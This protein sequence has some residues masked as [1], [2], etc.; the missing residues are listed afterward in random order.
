MARKINIDLSVNTGST[1]K[2]IANIDSN[3]E[4]LNKTVTDIGK[5]KGL[6]DFGD[7]LSNVEKDFDNL[8]TTV[9]DTGT[10]IEKTFNDGKE[11]TEKFS[12][13]SIRT[14]GSLRKELAN[15]VDQLD[16]V[17]VG[18][19]EFE[20]LTAAINDTEEAIS[21]TEGAFGEA[22]DRLR[23]LSGSGVERARASFGLLR[24]GITNL[25]LGK[26]QVGLKGLT[27]NF[28]VLGTAIAATGIG[29]LVGLISNLITNFDKLKESGGAIGAL[30]TGIGDGISFITD[31]LT[32]LTD[33][34]GLTDTETTKARKANEKYTQSFQ[35]LN[36]EL[37]IAAIKQRELSGDITETEGKTLLLEANF[38]SQRIKARTDFL[39]AIS[40]LD[41]EKDSVEIEN[42]KKLYATRL[43]V[44]R[45]N[46]NN[47]KLAIQNS[48]KAKTKTISDAEAKR[49]KQSIDEN[50]KRRE[51]ELKN[52]QKFFEELGKLRL[53]ELTGEDLILSQQE[54]KKQ[55]II[56]AFN[57]LTK[58]EQLKQETSF[59]EQLRLIN[60]ETIKLQ[61]EFRKKQ[62]E[63]SLDALLALA[64]EEADK[65]ASGNEQLE[66]AQKSYTE[67]L[68]AEEEKRKEALINRINT[69]FEITKQGF[70]AIASLNDL[71]STLENNRNI[72]NEKEL[73]KIQKRQFRRNQ[74]L[75]AT[76]T[77]INT[78][79]SIIK[80]GA[81]LGY[82]AAIPFQIGAGIAGAAQIASILAKRFDGNTPNTN[83]TT[84]SGLD[85]ATPVSP[86]LPLLEQLGALP[87][88][89][90]SKVF[91]TETDITNVLN[92]VQVIET[93]STFG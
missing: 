21:K 51:Q 15:L 79:E 82:P 55:G 64:N 19:P 54:E 31:N 11:A 89:Q 70:E 67:F 72:T 29:L 2:D 6:D 90:T 16:T 28:R 26:L 40:N 84:P 74:V 12:T 13:A 63:D 46:E 34:I 8:I 17:E 66:K 7:S 73:L 5:N 76:Q 44:I 60:Q 18:T 52:E 83:I 27:S 22:T 24:E 69:G 47:E 9:K 75:A 33:A 80:T 59:Q 65:T 53:G 1:E 50:N 77:G 87:T 58:E 30:F 23:T 41:S 38:N 20:R 48:E 62:S 4:N 81:N 57:A 92:G 45:V 85:G 32:K 37:E 68:K 78:A 88:Q 71:F 14:L 10:E 3:L 86:E 49:N 25:D 43:N 39:E 56:L 91:V 42:Q 35:D 93:A 36:N 61:E